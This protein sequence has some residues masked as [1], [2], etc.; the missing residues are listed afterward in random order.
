MVAEIELELGPDVQAA[1]PRDDDGAELEV[2]EHVKVAGGVEV[3]DR[4]G[5]GI[6]EGW[7]GN[8]SLLVEGRL[9]EN[10]LWTF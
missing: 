10:G 5:E 3:K 8:P 9:G 4:A 2:D 1:K 7:L 6:E